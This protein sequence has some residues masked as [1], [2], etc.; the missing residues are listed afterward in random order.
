MRTLPILALLCAAACA[1]EVTPVRE[2]LEKEAKALLDAQDPGKPCRPSGD[3]RD[4]LG[5]E[6]YQ[7]RATANFRVQGTFN[8]EQLA[9]IA[10]IAEAGRAD[11]LKVFEPSEARVPARIE[12]FVFSNQ[13]DFQAWVLACYPGTEERRKSQLDWGGCFIANPAIMVSWGDMAY[14]RE[15][16]AHQVTHLLMYLHF[17]TSLP[18]WL[19]EAAGARSGRRLTLRSSITCGL[20]GE[21]GLSTPKVRDNAVDWNDE[22]RR[23]LAA[24]KDVPIADLEAAQWNAVG[25]DAIIKGWS[26]LE[27]LAA[28]HGEGLRKYAKQCAT[29]ETRDWK[30]AFGVT[31]EEMNEMWRKRMVGEK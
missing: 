4:A 5:F 14:E 15:C 7:A 9:D 28:E 3:A 23:W 20:V 6:R 30:A 31:A 16:V 19:T 13:A 10:R 12:V 11:Y 17:G 22:I 26:L 27:Y 24:G 18:V 25:G 2:R 8:Q 21:E 29:G 1:Q